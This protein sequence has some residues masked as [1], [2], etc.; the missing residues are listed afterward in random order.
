MTVSASTGAG[1][2]G[3]TAQVGLLAELMTNTLDQDYQVAA[4]RRAQRPSG[5]RHS[6]RLVAASVVLLFGGMIAISAVRT[7]QQR[8]AA[9]AERDQLVAQL[10]ARQA[11]LDSLQS[12]ISTLQRDVATLQGGASTARTLEQSTQSSISQF[13]GIT[14]ASEVTGPGIRILAS[15]AP[16]STGGAAD[17]SIRDTDLQALVNAL[18]SSGAEAISINGYRLTSLT[19][20]R[21]AGSAI[22]VDYKS[23]VPPY[24]ID[25]I[26]DPDTL[27]AR[28]LESPGGMAWLGLK[29]NFGIGFDTTTESHL[30]LAGDPRIQLRQ[31]APVGSR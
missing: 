4:D 18:W 12:E 21:F 23:L 10:H 30:V 24:T 29:A 6:G 28:L 1:R 14:G 16:D 9:A 20:I 17:G 7:E 8:P 5:H 27:P 11:R 31:A 13:S 19:A 3:G 25:A 26:G 2:V 15:D 22:T